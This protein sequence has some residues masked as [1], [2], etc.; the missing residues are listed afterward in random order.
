MR[1]LARM[2]WFTLAGVIGLEV[3]ILAWTTST[4]AK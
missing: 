3:V 2:F 4:A 1:T